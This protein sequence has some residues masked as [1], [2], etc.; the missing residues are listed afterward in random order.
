MLQFGIIPTSDFLALITNHA[1]N[2]IKA[3]VLTVNMKFRK[4]KNNNVRNTDKT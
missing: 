1:T 2:A 4:L 3:I